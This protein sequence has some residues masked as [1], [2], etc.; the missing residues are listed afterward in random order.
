[1]NNEL[2][3][4]VNNQ[5]FLQRSAILNV[6]IYNLPNLIVQHLPVKEKV[7]KIDINRLRFGCFVDTLTSVDIQ[8]IVLIG[9]SLI[10]FCEIVVYRE[11]FTAS[12]S[13]KVI[14]NFFLL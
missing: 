1:M 11:N 10:E 14:D 8:E 4:K 9:G 7:N 5:T 2:V 3:S 12:P 13:G 6:K